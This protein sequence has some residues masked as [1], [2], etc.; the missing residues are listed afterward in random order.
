MSA[1]NDRELTAYAFR[2]ALARE[3]HMFAK[4]TSAFRSAGDRRVKNLCAGMISSCRN[5]INILEKEMKNLYL[6]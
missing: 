3:K 2:E 4:L 1:L 5:R 6:K